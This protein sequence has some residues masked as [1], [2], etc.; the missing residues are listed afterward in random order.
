MVVENVRTVQFHNQMNLVSS[1]L[2][3]TTWILLLDL[4]SVKAIIEQ[5]F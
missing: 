4:S 5:N 2:V 1:S 3:R